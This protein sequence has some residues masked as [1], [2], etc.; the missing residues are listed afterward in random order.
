[1][2]LQTKQYSDGG[3]AG[4]VT[5]RRN[6]ATGLNYSLYNA[7][8]AGMCAESGPWSIVCETHARTLSCRSLALA[9]CHI[10]DPASWCDLCRELVKKKD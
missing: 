8:Q 10:G 2:R 5:Q 1:M 3:Q 4:R 9:T 7:E 6:H